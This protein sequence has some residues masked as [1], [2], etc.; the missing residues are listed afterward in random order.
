MRISNDAILNLSIAKISGIP[1]NIDAKA[2]IYFKIKMIDD[3]KPFTKVGEDDGINSMH[4][5]ILKGYSTKN[6]RCRIKIMKKGLIFD[7]ILAVFELDL[8]NFLYKPKSDC[9]IWAP[10]L[11]DPTLNITLSLKIGIIDTRIKRN[12]Q[13]LTYCTNNKKR[14]SILVGHF[15]VY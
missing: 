15:K 8:I 3:R 10:S 9:I 4:S 12:S 2:A 7:T 13:V 5:I 6:C 14:K 1:F 11:I